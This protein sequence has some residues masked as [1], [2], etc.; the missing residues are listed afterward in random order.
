MRNQQ[1]YSSMINS[2]LGMEDE[3]AYNEV[4]E[5]AITLFRE[6]IEICSSDFRSRFGEMG[7]DLNKND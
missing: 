4:P 7:D 3:L 1:E 6:V 2:L 5:A